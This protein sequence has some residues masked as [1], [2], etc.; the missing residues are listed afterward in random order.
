[1]AELLETQ[2]I[3]EFWGAGIKFECCLKDEKNHSEK[4]FFLSYPPA[5]TVQKHQKPLKHKRSDHFSVRADGTDKNGG[6]C[7]IDNK[8]PKIRC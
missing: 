1:M 3:C 4:R 5:K 2:E 8:P 6:V 7:A